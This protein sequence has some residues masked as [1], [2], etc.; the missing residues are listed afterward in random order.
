MSEK[1][2]AFAEHRPD[3]TY[4]SGT[5]GWKQQWFAIVE[6]DG[7]EVYACGRRK[8]ASCDGRRMKPGKRIGDEIADESEHFTTC[9]ECGDLFDMR[10]LEEVLHHEEP[11][12]ERSRRVH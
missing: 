7:R 9:G 12:H 2:V 3:D 1:F 10:D 5:E 8:F 6:K 4:Q 11:G